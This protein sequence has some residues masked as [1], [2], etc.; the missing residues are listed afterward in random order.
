[1]LIGYE[2]C[3]DCDCRDVMLAGVPD[4]KKRKCLG[5][6]RGTLYIDFFCLSLSLTSV[7]PRSP[8][9]LG[10]RIVITIPIPQIGLRDMQKG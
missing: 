4:G 3:F 7:D 8:V 9:F 6:E 5:E 1:M 2:I 10:S